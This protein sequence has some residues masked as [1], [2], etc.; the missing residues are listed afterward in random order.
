MVAVS[1]GATAPYVTTEVD[2]FTL[3][4]PPVLSVYEPA[5]NI[6][7]VS[8]DVSIDHGTINTEQNAVVVDQQTITA[9]GRYTYYNNTAGV[10]TWRSNIEDL[11]WPSGIT[12]SVYSNAVTI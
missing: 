1:A 12:S 6:D 10:D 11:D 2:A 8:S 3:L 9:I 7:N 5:G 4:P